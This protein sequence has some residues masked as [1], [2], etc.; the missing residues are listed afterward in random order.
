MSAVRRATKRMIHP[1]NERRQIP[2]Q[3]GE[4]VTLISTRQGATE[5]DVKELLNSPPV[6]SLVERLSKGHKAL[7]TP[8]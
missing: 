3:S 1:R 2:F 4:S 6:K 5:L 8:D 7:R